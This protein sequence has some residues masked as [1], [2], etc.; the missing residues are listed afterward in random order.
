[1]VIVEFVIEILY[2]LTPFLYFFKRFLFYN[3]L[4]FRVMAKVASSGAE[5]ALA[6]IDGAP[7]RNVKKSE[8]F[9][10][11]GDV[12]ISLNRNVSSTYAK[13]WI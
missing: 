5:E 10:M 11:S 7:R 12:L 6:T 13:V 4:V 3:H 1:M 9:V 8:A 2:L